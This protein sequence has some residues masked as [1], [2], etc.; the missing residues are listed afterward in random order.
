MVAIFY[1]NKLYFNYL[2]GTDLKYVLFY[3]F[4]SLLLELYTAQLR[5]S[6]SRWTSN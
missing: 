5:F 4:I 1:G 2:Q 6:F 3:I